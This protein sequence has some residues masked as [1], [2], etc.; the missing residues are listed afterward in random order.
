MALEFSY[1]GNCWKW[2]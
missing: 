2:T 1:V